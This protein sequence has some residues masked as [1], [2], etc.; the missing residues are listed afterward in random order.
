ML[1]CRQHSLFAL[2]TDFEVSPPTQML[3]FCNPCVIPR[4]RISSGP[5]SYNRL[6]TPG[7][8]TVVESVFE[9]RGVDQRQFATDAGSGD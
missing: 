8:D 6:I 3:R 9:D 1:R 5:D 7:G 4:S 2:S